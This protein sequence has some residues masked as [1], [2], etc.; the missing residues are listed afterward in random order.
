LIELDDIDSGDDGIGLGAGVGAAVVA[1]GARNGNESGTGLGFD[2][3]DHR[4]CS[5]AQDG[6]AAC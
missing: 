5:G 2:D 4:K 1:V 3:V 6:G